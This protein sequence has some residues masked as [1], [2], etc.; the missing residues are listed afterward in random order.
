MQGMLKVL[1]CTL[2][3]GGFAL[4]DFAKN[5]IQTE[6]FT[7][8]D[9]NRIAEN[10]RDAGIDI[11]EVG[12]MSKPDSRSGFAIDRDIESLSQYI[13]KRTNK[14][15]MYVGLYRG[16][17]TDLDEI[18]EYSPELLDGVRVI[19]RYSE[20]QK[21]LD[22]CAALSKKGYKVFVQPMLTM[23]YSDDELER[24]IYAANEMKAYALY[25]VDS[26]GYMTEK[27][28]DRLFYYYEEELDSNIDIGFHAHNNLDMAFSNA[29]HFIDKLQNRNRIIDAC[30]TGMGQG[31]GNLQTELLVDYLNRNYGTEYRFDYIL[32]ICDILDK[33]REHDMKTWGYSPVRLIPAIHNAAYKY[34][35]A[36]K[37]R[38]HM[39]LAEINRVL[40]D[41]PEKL[42]HR[43]TRDDLEQILKGNCY[44]AGN[45]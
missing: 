12:C 15:Q 25:F 23:R 3:D 40:S 35:V 5:G 26:F 39:P 19:L 27:D 11:I 16:P 22:Y 32:A 36:M 18:P 14:N 10:A 9:R 31:A 28:I 43:Y 24:I 42:K 1:D 17:D 4:E 34:A 44:T 38:Y 21:S 6:L 33:F 13:P 20:L 45:K 8:E 37:W 2:R 30:V 41:I 7:E 29:R